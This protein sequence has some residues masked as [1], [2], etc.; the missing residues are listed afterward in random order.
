M[1]IDRKMLDS[2]LSLNDRQLQAL[3]VRL[4][5]ESGIDPAQFNINPQSVQSIRSAISNATDEDLTK[6]AEQYEANK[7]GGRR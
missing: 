4:I 1:Q 2:L 3:F 6:I 7:K 5:S